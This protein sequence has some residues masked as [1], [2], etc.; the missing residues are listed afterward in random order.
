M[1]MT[2]PVQLRPFERPDLPHAEPWFSDSETNRWLGDPDWPRLMLDLADQPL[3]E[4]RGASET[5]RFRW[6]ALVGQTP[7]GYIDCGT[8]DRWT[9][10][11]GE[12]VTQSIDEPS[13][14]LALA[15]APVSRRMGYGRQMLNALF[16]APEVADI[17]LF[18]AGVEPENV[19]CVS[20][21]RAAGFA[22][23]E[24]EPDFER[25]VYFLKSR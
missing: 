5:G 7:V 15:V 14:G 19:P 11:D 3:G 23:Q 22:I 12:K 8:F 10:W 17:K 9:S 18:G 24:S 4:F 6:L 20:C 21:L 2:A 13:A 1:V 16:E 25:I